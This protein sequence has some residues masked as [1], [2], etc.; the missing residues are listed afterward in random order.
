MAA[1]Q[2]QVS[3]S[4]KLSAAEIR[5]RREQ[6]ASN[7]ALTPAQKRDLRK[8]QRAEEEAQLAAQL[9]ASTATSADDLVEKRKQDRK[10]RLSAIESEV[11]T[12]AASSS[13]SWRKS[14]SEAPVVHTPSISTSFSKVT[15][16]P[17]GATKSPVNIKTPLPPS[18][19]SAIEKLLVLYF[20]NY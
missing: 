20:H 17:I 5:A 8:K 1:L 4:P 3:S 6:E 7:D 19:H 2:A 13:S 12:P 14:K 16:P 9:A 15:S 10:A 11:A 18:E